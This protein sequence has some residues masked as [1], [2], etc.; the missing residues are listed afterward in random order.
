MPIVSPS[1]RVHSYLADSHRHSIPKFQQSNFII[2]QPSTSGFTA[3]SNSGDLGDVSSG[4]SI[5]S[6]D[7]DSNVSIDNG[8]SDQ[9]GHR[10]AAA[11]QVSDLFLGYNKTGPVLSGV[12]MQVQSA[13][14]YGLLG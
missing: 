2:D 4:I 1:S 14:I 9:C 7:C 3:S 8:P 10:E 11:V 12:Q 13:S 6:D 5:D